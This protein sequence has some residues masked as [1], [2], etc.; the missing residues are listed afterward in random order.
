[1]AYPDPIHV[2]VRD[3]DYK[4]KE[5]IVNKGDD[6]YPK[7]VEWYKFTHKLSK[8]K[9][10]I[11]AKGGPGSGHFGHR[12]R[13][14]KIGGS[15]PSGLHAANEPGHGDI[16]LGYEG[17]L[18]VDS[19]LTLNLESSRFINATE[20]ERSRVKQINVEELARRTG[21]SEPHINEILKDWAVSS[22]DNNYS[23]LL[24]Q[25]AAAEELGVELGDWQ[26]AKLEELKEFEGK[27]RE[28]F[29][30]RVRWAKMDV[31]EV[32]HS[33]QKGLREA[34]ERDEYEK[35]SGE[36]RQEY[37]IKHHEAL[38]ILDKVEKEQ[39]LSYA[40][41]YD[42]GPLT[43]DQRKLFIREMYDWTQSDLKSL[44]FLHENEDVTLF[45]GINRDYLPYTKNDV[46]SYKGNAIE[47]WS[48]SDRSA[49]D[50]AFNRQTGTGIVL[51]ITVPRRN[52]ISTAVT[53]LGCLSEGE[54]IISGTIPDHEVRI[55]DIMQFDE[56]YND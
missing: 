36:H 50:F 27:D 16:R 32:E 6:D 24:L 8:K 1:M 46:V 12:G 39:N 40:G 48:V 4:V 41:L 15:L 47:S 19:M 29:D 5:I 52:I 54:V 21:I 2:T 30:E 33:W 26:K 9:Q 23:M 7:A 55:Y 17:N 14:G 42:P 49:A 35:W 31:E 56:V 22:N 18:D 37:S 53:G 25:E 43:K 34:R 11:I 20:E 44:A 51:A 13:P 38:K 10:I 28:W 3:G 45:R